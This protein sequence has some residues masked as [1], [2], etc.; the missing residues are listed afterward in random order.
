MPRATMIG[1]RF[2]DHAAF[3]EIGFIDLP[4]AQ[5][6]DRAPADPSN[7]H[8]PFGWTPPRLELRWMWTI[9]SEIIAAQTMILRDD[10]LADYLD[11]IEV[12]CD[13]HITHHALPDDDRLR[14]IESTVF[15]LGPGSLTLMGRVQMAVLDAPTRS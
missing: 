5:W 12:I 8:R 6:E 15:N 3:L 10:E 4:T 7:L 2:S 1:Q 9:S 13:L 11:V 14:L